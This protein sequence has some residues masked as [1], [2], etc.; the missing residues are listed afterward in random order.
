MSWKSIK[1]AIAEYRA[2]AKLLD[3]GYFV[4]AATEPQCPFDL[5][6]VS[7]K[8]ETRFIDVKVVSHRK[9]KPM[10]TEKSTKINRVHSKAQKK[11]KKESGIIIEFLFIK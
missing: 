5:I 10:W 11:F 1:G 7:P 3:Q 6:A 9:N 4:T 2:I 8:G